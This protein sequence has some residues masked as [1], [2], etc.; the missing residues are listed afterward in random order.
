MPFNLKD[1]AFFS[2]D[3]CLGHGSVI[4]N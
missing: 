4:L 3:M 2:T 1:A